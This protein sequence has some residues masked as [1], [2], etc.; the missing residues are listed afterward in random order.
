MAQIPPSSTTSSEEALQIALVE[1]ERLGQTNNAG[2]SGDYEILRRPSAPEYGRQ[3]S[4]AI[5]EVTEEARKVLERF[6][7][8]A[9]DGTSPPLCQKEEHP[10]AMVPGEVY[11]DLQP[12]PYQPMGSDHSLCEK[13]EV[14]ATKRGAEK[15]GAVKICHPESDY[16]D[17]HMLAVQNAA[18]AAA[19]GATAFS[20]QGTRLD[21]L[22]SVLRQQ[23]AGDCV[24]QDK[25]KLAI[26]KHSDAHSKTRTGKSKKAATVVA[27]AL[28]E[29][30][31]SSTED[32]EDT[33]SELINRKKKS[34]LRRATERLQRS[35]RR[36]GKRSI[37][38]CKYLP[39]EAQPPGGMESSQKSQP[40][41]QSVKG[42][43][44]QS[45]AVKPLNRSSS[46]RSKSS[47]TP[48]EA[49]A[50]D[51]QTKPR[52]ERS[53]TAAS[54]GSSTIQ[55][56]QEKRRSKSPLPWKKSEVKTKKKECFSDTGEKSKD[57]KSGGGM[58][59]GLLRQFRKRSAKLKRRLSNG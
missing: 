17:C 4:T 5:S 33:G 49:G 38:P 48:I 37:E 40:S 15:V 21:K 50:V 54:D 11:Q 57:G 12:T 43:K 41:T 7:K 25:S 58:L 8:I 13:A 56:A 10:Y 46:E 32:Y 6:L 55:V 39:T 28:E 45:T 24:M 42:T 3:K 16:V 59:D 27:A 22:H 19:A 14:A 29:S 52:R 26:P 51:I 53:P 31:T 2:D 23:A 20:L 44:Y 9:G 1:L 35:F 47:I 36:Q 34:L 30:T 18:A